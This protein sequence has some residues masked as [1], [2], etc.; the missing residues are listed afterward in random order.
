[1]LKLTKQ[2]KVILVIF[3]VLIII[4]IATYFTLKKTREG[5][6]INSGGTW[7][8]QGCYRDTKERALTTNNGNGQTIE[9]CQSIA[10]KLGHPH[11]GLQNGGECWSGPS[12]ED[13]AK[14]IKLED[15]HSDCSSS[16]G[17]AWSNQV[18]KYVPNPPPPTNN[19]VTGRYF[20]IEKDTAAVN[21]SDLT[22]G[23]APNNNKQNA[24]Y[25]QIGGILIYDDKGVLINLDRTKGTLKDDIGV[26]NNNCLN[27]IQYNTGRT[28]LDAAI[29]IPATGSSTLYNYLVWGGNTGNITHTLDS[30]N[31]WWEYDFGRDVNIAGFEILPRAECCA[32]RS[33]FLKVKVFSSNNRLTPLNISDTF[34]MF[35]NI[36]E[37]GIGPSSVFFT[38]PQQNVSYF[39]ITPKTI[40][41]TTQPITTTTQPITTTTQPITT[42][43]ITTRPITTQP[44]TT[45]PI[46]TQPITTPEIQS[47][48]ILKS[49]SLLND[50]ELNT[51]EESCK[52]SGKCTYTNNGC[53][54][55]TVF[56]SIPS[57]NSSTL[58]C[59]IIPYSN[60]DNNYRLT[61]NDSN[62][63]NKY[64][65]VFNSL[66]TV[67][68]CDMTDTKS[69]CNIIRQIN[70]AKSPYTLTFI[71]NSI[72]DN[73]IL[74]N[75]TVKNLTDNFDKDKM[76]G[77]LYASDDRSQA[78][79]PI[80]YIVEKG[81]P[82]DS[83]KGISS[84]VNK[85]D[86]SLYYAA[87]G[88]INNNASNINKIL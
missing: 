7:I 36:K 47:E 43:P 75:N 56:S 53:Y 77:I 31:T 64:N 76:K 82:L 9:S 57:I 67:N 45:Q 26:T 11:I 85:F 88:I 42:Q 83:I 28:L 32:I 18:Y 16:L 65:Y 86:S 10:N 40:P 66:S 70:G 49:L 71:N 39:Y 33:N 24:R 12:T 51:T 87:N 41:T 48:D 52:L 73:V 27:I 5:F 59:S 63:N 15:S 74:D 55:R 68:N 46:T 2:I 72:L 37:N 6:A 78:R 34:S 60:I 29:K 1:M 35:P 22:D 23:A 62:S 25:L 58:T 3:I 30:E 54:S 80:P 13:Y 38:T 4:S 44:I 79:I 8:R 20:R 50:C 69:Q 17:G 21:N 14:Y 19:Y 61:C 84:N 81:S